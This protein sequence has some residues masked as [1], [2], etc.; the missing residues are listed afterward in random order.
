MLSNPIFRREFISSCRS[1]R[2]K[3]LVFAYILSLAFVLLAMWPG[4]GVLSTVSDTGKKIFELFF[5]V[6]LSLLILLIPSFA[7]TSVTSERENN[8]YSALFTTLLTP[9]EIMS[10]K[11][12]S[13]VLM[14]IILVIL[15]IPVAS[16]T[17][18]TGGVTFTFLFKITAV[19]VMTAISYGLVG[20]ACSTLC[21]RSSTSILLNYVLI[22]VLAAGTWLPGALLR[23]MIGLSY[24]WQIMRSISPYDTLY[25]LLNPDAYGLTMAVQSTGPITP[26]MI[27]MVSSASVSAL[28]FMVFFSRILKP[29]A[30][31]AKTQQKYSDSK[32]ALKRKL[33]WPFYLIDPLKRKKPIARWSNPVY[34]AELRSKLFSNPKFIIRSVFAILI[35]S[36]LLLTLVSLQLG[37]KINPEKVWTVAIIFQIGIVALL[38]PGVSSGLITEEITNNTLTQL[39]MTPVGVGTFITGKLKA[40]F[41]YALIFIISSF[42]IMFAMSYLEMQNVFPE[43]SVLTQKWWA[44]VSEKAKD[45]SWWVDV[46]KTYRRVVIW[47]FILVLSTFTFLA[48]GLFASSIS[49]RTSIA[50]AIS[51]SI[52]AF[53][54]VITLS[55]V[56]LADRLSPAVAEKIL[57]MNPIIAAMQSSFGVYPEYISLWR[58]NIVFLCAA[59]VFFLATATVRTWLLFRKQE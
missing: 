40:T 12:A 55:P 1:L 27:F 56:A 8:T 23:N 41:F 26:F 4:G 37:D 42:F 53:L 15:A 47:I 21:A 3:L 54:C 45:Y 51:Y 31:F 13:A 17:A 25:Y 6:N 50:T 33:S 28:A 18:L 49:S 2:V 11:L 48:G 35:V 24:L 38:T 52:A 57:T 58:N 36:L 16:V 34:V 7:A 9:W 22:L 14:L 20:L 39:R 10:G 30:K 29:P 32:K 44:A 43:G 46:W 19:L 59:I 5:S